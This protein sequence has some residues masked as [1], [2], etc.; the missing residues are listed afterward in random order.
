MEYLDLMSRKGDLKATLSLGKL[1]YEGS[2]TLKRNV[3]K[4]KKYFMSV[5]RKYWTKDGKLISSAPPGLDKTASKA[6]GYIGR[7]FLRGEGTEQSFEKAI[8]WFKRGIANGDALCQYELGLMYRHG[9]G[10]PK[11]AVKAASY[12]KAAA[13]QDLPR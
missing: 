10:L 3:R 9:H 12:F 1:H 6:A 5:A 13:D 7:M 11:D 8:T 2:R 4:A